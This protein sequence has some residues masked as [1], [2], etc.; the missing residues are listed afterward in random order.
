MS[1]TVLNRSLRC[2]TLHV[3]W[4]PT[5]PDYGPG[6]RF[7]VLHRL[8]ADRD[9][10]GGEHAPMTYGKIDLNDGIISPF[11]VLAS[12]VQNRLFEF[13]PYGLDFS[14]TLI[15]FGAGAGELTFAGVVAIVALVL[16]YITNR[17]D[18]DKLGAIQTWIAVVTIVLVVA[19]PVVPL[20][21]TVIGASTV[22]GT[23]SLI[24]QSS[25]FYALS[26]NG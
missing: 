9:R 4:H 11:F 5:E 10:R 16:A 19:Q 20:L 8:R 13:S 7:G 23:V 2:A 21:Q 3:L 18:F 17:P 15:D 22:L 12:G 26:Y 6:V 24:I 14:G 25:G 1:F